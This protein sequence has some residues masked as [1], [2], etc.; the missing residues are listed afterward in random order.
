[1]TIKVEIKCENPFIVRF[2]LYRIVPIKQK[3]SLFIGVYSAE[4]KVIKFLQMSVKEKINKY[5]VVF[6]VGG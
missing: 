4:A 3:F 2:L 5:G 6:K 1:V